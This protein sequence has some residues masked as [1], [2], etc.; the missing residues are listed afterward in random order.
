MTDQAR[1]PEELPNLT[2]GNGHMADFNGF[3]PWTLDTPAFLARIREM[4]Q[5]DAS[6]DSEVAKIVSGLVVEGPAGDAIP[7]TI[8]GLKELAATRAGKGKDR[9]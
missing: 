9:P 4:I 2:S 6:M 3:T 1:D 7:K 8:Q 5:G